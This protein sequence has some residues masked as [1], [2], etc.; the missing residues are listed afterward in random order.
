VILAH[1]LTG[2]RSGP[3]ELLSGLSARLCAAAGVRVVRFDFRGSGDSGGEFGQTTFAGMTRAFAEI[4]TRHAEPGRP[5]IC[6][7]ISIGGVPAAVAACQLRREGPLDVAGVV[8]M[9]SDLIQGVRFGVAGLTAIR[10]G[11]FHL[12]QAFFRERERLYPRTLLSESGLPF[13][14][15]Y[16]RED[17]KVAAETR[18]FAAHGEVA[19]LDSDHLFESSQARCALLGAWLKYLGPLLDSHM[20]GDGT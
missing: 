2:D 11:E 9:S 12:P 19:E 13:L 15:I 20:N 16:G 6:A 3:A 1:G 8:L 18:W 14:L 5:V 4:A 17:A 10:G 7:G